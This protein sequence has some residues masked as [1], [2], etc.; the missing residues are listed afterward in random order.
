MYFLIIQDD[1]LYR[2]I[3]S[4]KYKMYFLIAICVCSL[5]PYEGGAS[6]RYGLG[7]FID[8]PT[9]SWFVILQL[10]TEDDRKNYLEYL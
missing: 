3:L 1:T 10:V 4:E 2:K 5:C 9:L 8:M 7:L 6:F